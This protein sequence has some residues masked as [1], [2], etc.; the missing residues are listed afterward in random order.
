MEN[1]KNLLRFDLNDNLKKFI[2]EVELPIKHEVNKPMYELIKHI[3]SSQYEVRLFYTE[4]ETIV[5]G[6]CEP[7]IEHCC[8]AIRVHDDTI[9][10][11]PG[12]Y[13]L[14]G[15]VIFTNKLYNRSNET[16]LIKAVLGTE[17]YE[18]NYRYEFITEAFKSIPKT[19]HY[20]R[21]M[22]DSAIYSIF[23]FN[24]DAICLMNA[25]GYSDNW[26]PLKLLIGGEPYPIQ[27]IENMERTDEGLLIPNISKI[28][29]LT[30]YKFG[31]NNNE[32][33]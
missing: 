21:I 18:T 3:A 25:S 8:V 14:R 19:C 4:Y 29:P 30:E 1:I 6:K 12:E 27:E 11:I 17:L 9:I 15:E 16:E 26:S 28:I 24:E 7:D 31:G 22:I 33:E 2:R 13:I 20:K 23:K 10:T 32:E 5:V